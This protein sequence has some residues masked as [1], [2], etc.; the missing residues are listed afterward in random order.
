MPPVPRFPLG[1]NAQTQQPVWIANDALNLSCVVFGAT[2]SGKT[3]TLNHFAR[4]AMRSAMPLILIDAKGDTS[5]A[6]KLQRW[7]Q[8]EHRPFLHWSVQGPAQWN[9]LA[10][11]TPSE[12]KDKLIGL[13]EWTEPHY[14]YASERFLQTLIQC[15]QISGHE[16][17][18][19]GGEK[20]LVRV[21]V[22]LAPP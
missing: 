14:R 18:G 22:G 12:L 20:S 21:P 10:E 7:A 3:S 17:R 19:T 5:W 13:T 15:F 16:Y 6:G 9:P 1:V 4:H 2:G 8:L 11:G